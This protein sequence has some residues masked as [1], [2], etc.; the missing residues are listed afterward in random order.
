M[1]AC[2]TASPIP[3]FPTPRP[4][5]LYSLSVQVHYAGGA[6]L[7]AEVDVGYEDKANTVREWH[8]DSPVFSAALLFAWP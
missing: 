5:A 6:N 4:V 8:R 2:V 3:T 1:G 7:T